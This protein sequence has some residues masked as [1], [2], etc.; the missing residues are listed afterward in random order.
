M[1]KSY[2]LKKFKSLQIKKG[3]I[4]YISFFYL[5][6][7]FCEVSPYVSATPS[8]SISCQPSSP[9]VII[10]NTFLEKI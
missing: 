10:F 2:K 1:F 7:F 9:S 4:V 6:V 3:N 8:G 5:V